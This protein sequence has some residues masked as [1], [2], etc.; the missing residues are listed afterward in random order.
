MRYF[1][2]LVH[3]PSDH[4]A[5]QQ[6][7]W[8]LSSSSEEIL[9]GS[10]SQS[11]AAEAAEPYIYLTPIHA[12]SCNW[13]PTHNRSW[14][15]YSFCSHSEY[16]CDI[17]FQN[18]CTNGSKELGFIESFVSFVYSRQVPVLFTGGAQRA[19]TGWNWL[20]GVVGS[21]GV[22]PTCLLAFQAQVLGCAG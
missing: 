16:H 18:Y 22:L 12:I 6:L 4:C 20:L 14:T 15:S 21:S 9:K 10:L 19:N 11:F 2:C 8:E 3:K 1:P 17:N 7:V 13:Y 5:L